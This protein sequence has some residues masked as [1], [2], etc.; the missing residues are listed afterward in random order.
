MRRVLLV[1]PGYGGI[2][3]ESY[4]AA[5]TCSKR[6]DS[7]RVAIMRP[8][9]SLLAHTFNIGVTHCLNERYEYFAMLHGDVAPKDGWLD[10]L[11]DILDAGKCDVIHAVAP[12]KDGRGLTS[13]AVAYWDDQFEPVR[14][15]TTTELKQL[16]NTFTIEDVREHIDARAK[17]LLPNTGCMCFR[18]DTW[19]RKF[20]G[21][22]IN[23]RVATVDNSEWS[24]DVM[25]EDWNFGHWCGRNY[26]SVGGVAEL[27]LRHYGRW[28]FTNTTAYGWPVDK[29]YLEAIGQGAPENAVSS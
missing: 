9:A 21:F 22:T 24:I 20:P 26:I 3:P 8:C 15:L 25:P 14:R 16:P 13:T 5:Q 18:A 17:R 1:Q 6:K 27:G 29:H 11:L 23:D 19:F 10:D 2:E 12:I 7:T 4:Q 28:E